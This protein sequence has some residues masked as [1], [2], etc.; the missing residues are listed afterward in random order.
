MSLVTRADMHQPVAVARWVVRS[1]WSP[2][3]GKLCFMYQKGAGII[4]SV[5]AVGRGIKSLT[6]QEVFRAVQSVMYIAFTQT[7]L[8]KLMFLYNLTAFSFT[9]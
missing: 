5:T 8:P 6:S 2:P 3:H 1:V 7:C 9:F 4:V